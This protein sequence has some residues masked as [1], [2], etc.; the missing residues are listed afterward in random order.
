MNLTKE[1]KNTLIDENI[2]I[3]KLIWYLGNGMI[4]HKQLLHLLSVMNMDSSINL[5]K[6]I[7]DLIKSDILTKKQ[8]ML[9]KSNMLIMTA[10]AIAKFV[11]RETRDIAAISAS[12]KT[13]QNNIF[14]IECIINTFIP[15]LL[16]TRNTISADEII[17]MLD[18]NC[19]TLHLTLKDTLEYYKYLSEYYP[20]IWTTDFSDD[21]AILRVEKANQKLRLTKYDTI[22]INPEDQRIKDDY[23]FIKASMSDSKRCQ[24]FYNISNLMNTSMA[25]EFIRPDGQNFDISIGIYDNGNLTVERVSQLSA[26]VYRMFDRY[27]EVP[28]KFHLYVNVYCYNHEA[29]KALIQDS[30]R[31]AEDLYGY[32]KNTRQLEHLINNGV[33]FPYCEDNIVFYYI[34]TKITEHYNISS[35]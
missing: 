14:K 33:R 13:I 25:I 16:E 31:R 23:D 18:A 1:A 15:V 21:T 11:D 17:N 4:L 10:P 30:Q 24:D 7:S 9:S 19:S 28:R 8:V 2:E 32:T 35:K 6:R 5:R 34:D 20:S 12:D 27:L 22:D 26:Y 3:L 29:A